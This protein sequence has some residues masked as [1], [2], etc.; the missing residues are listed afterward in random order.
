MFGISIQGRGLVE[1]RLKNTKTLSR[2]RRVKSVNIDLTS[3]CNT[4]GSIEAGLVILVGYFEGVQLLL[5]SILTKTVMVRAEKM[6]PPMKVVRRR[7]RG[8]IYRQRMAKM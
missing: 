4:E 7:M 3:L 8:V 6:M 2:R 5:V 1:V